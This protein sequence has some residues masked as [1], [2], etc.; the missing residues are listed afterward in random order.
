MTLGRICGLA[1]LTKDIERE[2]W[3]RRH[4][5]AWLGVGSGNNFQSGGRDPTRHSP[6]QRS[7][8][9]HLRP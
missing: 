5:A 3:Y 2:L 4:G 1:V 6:N 8:D 9:R 7:F